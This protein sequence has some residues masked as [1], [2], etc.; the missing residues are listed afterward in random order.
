MGEANTKYFQAKATIK[1]R[2]NSIAMLKDSNGVEHKDHQSKAAILYS[3]FKE[4]LGTNKQTSNPLLLHTLLQQDQLL[5]DLEA[6]FTHEEIDNIIKEM[7]NDKAP[8]PDGFNADQ[9]I[10]MREYCST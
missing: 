2:N 3:A 1:M 6:P 7:P 8:G 10:K 5:Q 4:R 9:Q